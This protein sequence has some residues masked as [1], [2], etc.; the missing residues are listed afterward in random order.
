MAAHT[1]TGDPGAE[2]GGEGTVDTSGVQQQPVKSTSTTGGEIHAD[3]SGMRAGAR[4]FESTSDYAAG[5]EGR[6]LGGTSRL[7]GVWGTD[8]T[9]KNFETE[10]RRRIV[11][12]TDALKSIREGLGAL[13]ES[14]DSWA[15]GYAQAEEDNATIADGLAREAET[16][17][18]QI[19]QPGTGAGQPM[20]TREYARY[21]GPNQ[22][23]VRQPSGGDGGEPVETR[24]HARYM[25]PN[26]GLVQRN[27]SDGDGGVPVETREPPTHLGPNLGLVQR[28]QS[29]GDGGEPVETREH[30]RYMGPNVGLVRQPS[31]GAGGVP[32]ETREYARYMGPNVGL[33]RQPS[34]GDGGV[35]VETREP[36]THL[37]P[38]LGLV[39][40]HPSDG[41]GGEPVE[42]REYAMQPRTLHGPVRPAPT[43]GDGGEPHWIPDPETGEL[44]RVVRRVPMPE[45]TYG[46][47]TAQVTGSTEGAL[48]VEPAPAQPLGAAEGVAVAYGTTDP[49]PEAIRNADGTVTMTDWITDPDTGELVEVVRP[50]PTQIPPEP[51][52]DSSPASPG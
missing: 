27:P 12:A 42:T 49:A 51:L 3:T 47:G 43:A 40:R 4:M 17:S 25:G 24:E 19:Y 8:S 46:L 18:S 48:P 28:N 22:G 34:G 36:P 10:Y 44:L 7:E 1:T 9:G 6:F 31:D 13:P 45:P 16:Q 39:Q 2:G 29:G 23:L 11:E 20:E 15:Q 35:P 21:M 33:V 30:A 14:V 5:I 41:D 50:V 37:G 52:D 26:L 38:N 32:V